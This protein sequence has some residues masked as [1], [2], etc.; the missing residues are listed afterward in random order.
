MDGGEED[1]LR[2]ELLLFLKRDEGYFREHSFGLE[3]ETEERK[4][5]KL[6]GEQIRRKLGVRLFSLEKDFLRYER[7]QTY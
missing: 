1:L 7:L 6:E 2:N 3:V 4:G 5:N